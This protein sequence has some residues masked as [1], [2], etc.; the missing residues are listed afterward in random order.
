MTRTLEKHLLACGFR[1]I[2]QHKHYI[3]R[4]TSGQ[5]LVVSKTG[6]DWRMEQK[7]MG[8]VRRIMRRTP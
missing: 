8:D 3:Y 6:S 5:T 7:V 2:R 1:L 4:H